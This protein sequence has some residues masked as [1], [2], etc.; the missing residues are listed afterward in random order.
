M[1][2]S[3]ATKPSLY[4]N[5][6]IITGS[7]NSGDGDGIDV[8]GLISGTNTGIIRSYDAHDLAGLVV[9]YSEGMSVGGGTIV[10]SGTIEG[11]TTGTHALGRGISFVGNDTGTPGVRET[12]YGDV[13][14]TNSGLIKRPE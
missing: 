6:G 2:G 7:G 8:D 5:H 9:A 1:T 3:T 11:L 14:V 13:K 12:I 10:N 4:I